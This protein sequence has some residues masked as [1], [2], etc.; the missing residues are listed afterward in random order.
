MDRMQE[1]VHHLRD[2]KDGFETLQRFKLESEQIS[3]SAQESI[4][5]LQTETRAADER[6]RKIESAIQYLIKT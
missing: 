5:S 4:R 2:M 1:E 6:V 3:K